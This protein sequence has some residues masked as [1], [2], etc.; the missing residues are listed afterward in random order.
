MPKAEPSK[1]DRDLQDD[2][3]RYLADAGTRNKN[4]SGLP[5]SPEQAKR[6]GKFARFLARR[7]YRDRLARSLRYSRMF[8]SA[9]GRTAEQVVDGE[10]FQDFLNECVMGSLEGAE[11]VCF[12]SRRRHT[13]FDCDWSSDVCSSDLGMRSVSRAASAAH[14]RI[15]GSASSAPQ[16]AAATPA[17][18][19]P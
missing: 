14:S 2:V 10:F 4:S 19:T 8:S 1:S 17:S 5:L 11:R 15:A 18:G 13:R 7:Y 3:I 6:A 12:S 9:L 16:Y